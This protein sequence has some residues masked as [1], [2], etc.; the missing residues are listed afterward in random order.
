MIDNLKVL[1]L[2]I[3]RDIKIIDIKK[4]ILEKV[5]DYEIETINWITQL[6]LDN[7][8]DGYYSDKRC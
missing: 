5:L 1:I 6:Y 4:I 8:L 7:H 2:Y 3:L